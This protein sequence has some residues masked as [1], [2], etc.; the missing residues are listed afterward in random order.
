MNV[1]QVLSDTAARIPGKTAVLFKDEKITY[2]GLELMATRLANKLRVCGVARGD[3]VA[4]VLP[5]SSRWVVSY[6]AAMKIGAVAVPL[7]F[8]FKAEEL[9]PI[10]RDA[11][12]RMIVTSSQHPA[13]GSGQPAPGSGKP[14]TRNPKHGGAA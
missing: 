7:D 9:V 8:R 12:A 14:E 10:F 5:N 4:I 3:R 13:Y 2:A 11:Q 6:L 1:G